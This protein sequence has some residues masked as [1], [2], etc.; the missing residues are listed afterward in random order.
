MKNLFLHINV[1]YLICFFKRT[2][3]HFVRISIQSGC[4]HFSF[5]CISVLH[6][7]QYGYLVF[8]T[9]DVVSGSVAYICSLLCGSYVIFVHQFYTSSN[10]ATWSTGRVIQI[11]KPEEVTRLQKFINSTSNQ[12]IINYS[13]SWASPCEAIKEKYKQI[14]EGNSKTVFFT[15][16]V[17]AASKYA[18]ACGVEALPTFAL[19]RYGFDFFF[20]F[21]ILCTNTL[22][23]PSKQKRIK[24]TGSSRS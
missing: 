19:Y 2:H 11:S 23:H 24:A 15:V 16:D 21:V 22:Q 7:Q 5:F 17:V 18:D 13:A 1:N 14:A 12:I 10:M 6:K 4:L 3:L 9:V 8:F 20:L